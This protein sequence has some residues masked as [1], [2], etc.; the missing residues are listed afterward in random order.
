[1]T[2]PGMGAMS[3]LCWDVNQGELLICG[4]VCPELIDTGTEI[5]K[6]IGGE[7]ELQAPFDAVCVK[8]GRD[9]PVMESH[10]S[11]RL[12]AALAQCRRSS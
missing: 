10:G 5:P 2:W 6:L 12:Q 9:F 11:G 3:S 1:M 7:A 4:A 8:V